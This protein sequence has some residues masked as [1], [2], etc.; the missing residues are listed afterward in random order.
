AGGRTTNAYVTRLSQKI[1]SDEQADI[2]VMSGW[3]RSWNVSLP[4]ED[5]A[6]H[7]M[8]GMLGPA[9]F[10]ELK[11]RSG[12]AFDRLWLTVLAKHLDSGVQM[13][14]TVRE[15]GIHAPTAELAKKMITNQRALIGEIVKQ[16]A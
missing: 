12:A 3:L 5:G 15:K 16:V 13:A 14:E 9:Q 2:T 1:I 7:D 8:P 10:A 11:R 4:P 6:V